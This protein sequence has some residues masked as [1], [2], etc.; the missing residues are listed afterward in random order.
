MNLTVKGKGSVKRSEFLIAIPFIMKKMN[1]HR[2]LPKIH[3]TV[4][5]DTFTPFEGYCL[6]LDEDWEYKIGIN[7]VQSSDRTMV[8]STLAHELV[9]LKQFARKELTYAGTKFRFGGKVW[10]KQFPDCLLTPWEIEAYG[11]ERGL[12]YAYLEFTHRK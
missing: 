7:P 9:H 10:D 5:Y 8:I 3:L 1:A 4:H 2:L 12:A 11:M 6:P